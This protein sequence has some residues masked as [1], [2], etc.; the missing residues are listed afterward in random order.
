MNA[1]FQPS[2]PPR[3]TFLQGRDAAG[4]SLSPRAGRLSPGR[5]PLDAPVG[6]SQWLVD[7][8]ALSRCRALFARHGSGLAG[9]AGDSRP[10]H[11]SMMDVPPAYDAFCRTHFASVKRLQPELS[12][13]DACPAYAIALS[14][15]AVLCVALDDEREKRFEQHW[16]QI[17][18]QSRLPWTQ[19]RPLIADGCSAL[20]RMDPLARQR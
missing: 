9:V 17:R 20:G 2:S 6:T 12:W 11:L 19:A 1:E 4:A 8:T 3:P 7:L 16:D 15:H 13:E 10:S 18:G 14:A 5:P